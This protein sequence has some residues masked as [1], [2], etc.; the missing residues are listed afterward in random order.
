[1]EI[2][3]EFKRYN[4]LDINKDKYPIKI[5]KFCILETVVP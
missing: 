1:M 5:G 3:R 4:I 2:Y